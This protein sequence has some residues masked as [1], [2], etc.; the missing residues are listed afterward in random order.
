MSNTSSI[1]RGNKGKQMF[2]EEYEL[3][4]LVLVTLDLKLQA[5][6]AQTLGSRTTAGNNEFTKNAQMSLVILQWVELQR[7]IVR[8]I[9]ALEDTIRIVL[10]QNCNSI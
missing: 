1:S 7:Q 2:Q 10:N 9:D 8:E 5:A 4:L 3:Q 6:T